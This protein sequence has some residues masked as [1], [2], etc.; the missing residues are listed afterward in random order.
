MTAQREIGNAAR[1]AVN[2]TAEIVNE[3]YTDLEDIITCPATQADPVL[4]VRLAR[5][6][7]KLAKA[8]LW[9]KGLGA[10]TRP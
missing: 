3:A 6:A 2:Q 10:Q 5:I 7:L 4:L 9:L 1:E 8:L